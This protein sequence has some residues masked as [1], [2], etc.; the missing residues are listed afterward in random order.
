[1][2]SFYPLKVDYQ[3]KT[4][5]IHYLVRGRCLDFTPTFRLEGDHAVSKGS[6]VYGR[7]ARQTTRFWAGFC[8]GSIWLNA[9]ADVHIS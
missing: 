4:E 7:P 9:V 2:R 5:L 1:M 8:C 6:E 3:E